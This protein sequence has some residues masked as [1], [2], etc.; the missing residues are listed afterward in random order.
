ML[1]GLSPAAEIDAVPLPAEPEAPSSAG[2]SQPASEIPD[3]LDEIVEVP[4]L[5]S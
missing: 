1:R 5:G 4:S 3:I 2:A